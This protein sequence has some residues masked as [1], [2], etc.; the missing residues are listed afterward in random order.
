MS[1]VL[2]CAAWLAFYCTNSEWILQCEQYTEEEKKDKRN[3]REKERKTEGRKEERK[4]YF[5]Q[6]I[7]RLI[8]GS[9][10]TLFA[11]NGAL[12]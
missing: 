6:Y 9:R 3:E 5:I 7:F 1:E 2:F 11:L 4:I 8:Q 10:R 12:D